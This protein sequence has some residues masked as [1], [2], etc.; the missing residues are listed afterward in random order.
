MILLIGFPKREIE[1]L[2]K[3]LDEEIYGVSED[4]AN[5]ILENVIKERKN[6]PYR[7]LGKQRIVIMHD[8]PK[9]NLGEI[10]KKIR[11]LIRD[12]I[13]FATSTPT[14]L[15]WQLYN[16]MEELIEEDEYFRSK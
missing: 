9:E 8:I 14:S 7:R 10:I 4:L 5:S 3:A 6:I 12:H 1:L 13:I 11:T 2:E 15:K 16:L